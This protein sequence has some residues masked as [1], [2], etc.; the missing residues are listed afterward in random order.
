M[1]FL[2]SKIKIDLNMNKKII[3]VFLLQVS[4]LFAQSNSK[5]SLNSFRNFNWNSRPEEIR[6]KEDA[7]FLQS[8]SGFGVYALSFR[9]NIAGLSARIDY[10]FKDSMLVEGSYQVRSDNSFKEN[11]KKVREHLTAQHGKPNY[12][13]I[14]L[15]TSAQPWVKETDLNSFRG[16][17]LYWEFDNGFIALQ[18]SKYNEEVTITILYVYN[19]KIG[20]YGTADVFTLEY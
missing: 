15:Y 14:K 7:S 2:K 13:A 6:E 1:L 8:F 16:P 19:Q 11:F 10:T 4:F 5:D 12:W 9:G 18:P 3:V 20:D 17:E